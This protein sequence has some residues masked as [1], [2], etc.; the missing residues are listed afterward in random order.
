M[1]HFSTV[2]WH[3]FRLRYTPGAPLAPNRI[4]RVFL[5][6]PGVPLAPGGIVRA[7]D[8][9]GTAWRTPGQSIR[10]GWRGRSV[11][12][13]SRAP[14][15]QP[16]SRDFGRSERAPTAPF[17]HPESP[18]EFE[19]HQTRRYGIPEVPLTSGA[20][21]APLPRSYLR[22]YILVRQPHNQSLHDHKCIASSISQICY[23]HAI[24]H[25]PLALNENPLA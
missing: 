14:A 24:K 8:A 19:G 25:K 4:I 20:R 15:Q 12:A 7:M 22:L 16:L 11:G 9:V 13:L 3:S 18:V 5:R 6:R 21:R 1:A 23:L 17:R 2:A 10:L